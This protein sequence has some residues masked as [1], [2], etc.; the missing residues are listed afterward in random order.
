[1]SSLILCHFV[2]S[3]MICS[4]LSPACCKLV[5]YEVSRN[6]PRRLYFSYLESSISTSR[7]CI[8]KSRVFSWLTIMST[9]SG[10]FYT[11]TIFKVPSL[12]SSA[13]CFSL[14]CAD[15]ALSSSSTDLWDLDLV[16]IYSS[17]SILALVFAISASSFS[18][19]LADRLWCLRP[20]LSVALSV[21]FSFGSLGLIYCFSLTYSAC[22]VD[23]SGLNSIFLVIYQTPIFPVFGSTLTVGES[24]SCLNLIAL[25]L[26]SLF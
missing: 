19:S 20:F 2:F 1:M 7:S 3:F 9:S 8:P 22:K 25:A 5:M 16:C 21:Y 6:S 17:L 13:S 26:N 18:C 11:W 15:F 23:C 24:P 4:V 10:K 12:S 14:P